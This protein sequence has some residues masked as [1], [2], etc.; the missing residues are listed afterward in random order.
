MILFIQGFNAFYN[1]KRSGYAD[2]PLHYGRVPQW[3]YERMSAL[4][5][6]IIEV[7]V[8]EGGPSEVLR[9]LS[10]PFWFQAFGSVLGMDWHS[11]GITTSVMG[12]LKQAVNP[13]SRDLGLYVCGGRG[14]HSRRTPDEIREVAGRDGLDAAYLTRCSRLSAKIDNTAVQDGFQIYLHSFVIAAGGEWAV[15][16]QGLN[17]GTGLARRYHWHSPSIR[18]FVDEPHAFIYG[19]SRGRI[20][21]MVDHQAGPARDAVS[22]IAR[23]EPA[24]ML[25]EIRTLVM[26]RRHD[27]TAADVDLKRLGAVLALAHER[28]AA[29]FENVLLLEGLGPRT[30]QSLALVSEVIYG[31]P[32]RFD[33]PA[34]F[35]FAHG[36]K[37]GK[38]FPV[39]LRVYDETI[40]TLRQAVTRA[41][42]G[43]NDRRR[44]L[45]SLSAAAERLEDQHDPLA[46][47]DRV[48]E[49]ELR[50]S[51][52]YGGRTVF[53]KVKP[54]DDG[55]G[56]L[57]D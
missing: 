36:G 34:R 21:N 49:K 51:H 16:Q 19:R 57:F 4:G 9:R 44:A 26:P 35:S 18:S 30:M 7:I 47:F 53:G 6:A 14:K 17:D 37:D 1:M 20:L 39:P 43:Y 24:A 56:K 55:Q 15:V 27:V 13:R 10:D 31:A 22:A 25:R 42:M 11:S 2:L 40:E 54:P 23:E 33:D 50:E 32:C 48:I 46:H 28:N 8:S 3:L 41:K 5:G 29:D 12:A 45:K 38:P 52:Q